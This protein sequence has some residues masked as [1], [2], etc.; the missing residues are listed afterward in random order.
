MEYWKS[1]IKAAGIRAVRTFA[2]TAAASIGTDAAM[3]EIDWLYMLSSS[4]LSAILSL[5]TSLVGLPELKV[6]GNKKWILA[7]GIRALKT[8][9]QAALSR[10]GSAVLIGEVDWIRVASTA[11]VAG[12]TSILLSVA[13]L[14]EAE[15]DVSK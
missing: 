1:W 8:V 4:A 14:P 13:G 12:L 10:I 11:V 5:I 7:A 6:D 3:G 2:E 9:A 15:K